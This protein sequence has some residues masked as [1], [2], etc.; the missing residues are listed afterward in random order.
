MLHNIDYKNI[1]IFI[2][3]YNRLHYLKLLVESLENKGY[4]NISIIDN[5]SS[6]PPLLDYLSSTKHKVF[7]MDKNYGHK[8]FWIH[9]SF[10]KIIET[11]YYVVTDPD[12]LPIQQCPD[13]FM[14]QFYKILQDNPKVPKVG[15]SLKIDD[16]P[17]HNEYKDYIIKWERGFYDKPLESKGYKIYDAPI[18]TTFA[19]YRPTIDILNDELFFNAIRTGYPYQARHLAWYI[20]QKQLDEESIF[21]KQH[22]INGYSTWYDLSDWLIETINLIGM[23]KAKQITIKSIKFFMNKIVANLIPIKTLRK[24]LRNT[25]NRFIA[26][27]FRLSK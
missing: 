11:Q 27:I 3:S 5:Q 15:F 24:K 18:D 4:T 2:I 16:I 20:N 22:T 13:D 19:L 23:S 12:I 1:P 21:Y 9:E 10:R 6:Y 17:N 25:S 14:E 26:K 8:V 7:Y